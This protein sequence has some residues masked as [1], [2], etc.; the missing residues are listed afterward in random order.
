MPPSADSWLRDSKSWQVLHGVLELSGFSWHALF[1]RRCCANEAGTYAKESCSNG[2]V[3][4]PAGT[5]KTFGRRWWCTLN[6]HLVRSRFPET[7]SCHHGE[8][9][10]SGFL[11][12]LFREMK[13]YISI[14]LLPAAR[15]KNF[16]VSKHFYVSCLSP[17]IEIE[18]GCC[19]C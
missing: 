8:H 19:H 2:L 11:E 17:R 7:V 5:T 16:K 15:A 12:D 1:V 13:N 3:R 6:R 18:I 10:I 9:E 14:L 4:H